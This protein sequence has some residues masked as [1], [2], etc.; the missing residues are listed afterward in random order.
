MDFSLLLFSP[1]ERVCAHKTNIKCKTRGSLMLHH[2]LDLE[3]RSFK[4]FQKSKIY[5]KLHCCTA[6]LTGDKIIH[7]QR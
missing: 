4:V 7:L 1:S 2:K 6:A 5:L 3:I